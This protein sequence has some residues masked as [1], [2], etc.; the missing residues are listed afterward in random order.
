M[1]KKM[2]NTMTGKNRSLV[3]FTLAVV[4]ACIASVWTYT[5]LKGSA[6]GQDKKVDT[7]SVAV[8]AVDMAWGSVLSKETI[9]MVPYLR[10]NLPAG[11]F[12][13]PETLTGRTIIYPIKANEPILTSRLAPSDFKGGGV[14]AVVSPS[15]RAMA[16]KVDKVIGV[17]GFIHPGN[18]VDV[19]VTLSEQNNRNVPIAKTVLENVLVLATGIEMEQSQKQEKAK[20]VDVI[21]L[22]VTPEEGE[23]LALAA[24][25]GKLQL[26]LRN[27]S[28]TENVNTRGTTIPI[29]LS[30]YSGSSGSMSEA[31]VPVKKTVARALAAAPAVQQAFIVELVRGNDV[32][33]FRFGKGE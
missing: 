17:S 4:I 12:T 32:D 14:A 15:K 30:S 8:A 25:E 27:F 18:R 21:T 3:V 19:L 29:L 33:K 1:I 13:D 9:R 28:D 20:P 26:S 16:V 24:A 6:S 2:W 5:A 22:E 31:K 11:H 10:E 7:V 23:K